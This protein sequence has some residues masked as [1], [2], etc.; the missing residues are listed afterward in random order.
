MLKL[1]S[2][3][4]SRYKS[5]IHPTSVFFFFSQPRNYV[6]VR[7]FSPV[8][9]LYE[10]E[11]QSSSSKDTATPWIRT[12]C[13]KPLLPQVNRWCWCAHYLIIDAE[14]EFLC[15]SKNLTDPFPRMSHSLIGSQI[16]RGG[17]GDTACGASSARNESH[18][19]SNQLET[20]AFIFFFFFF[21]I[22]TFETVL[23]EFCFPARVLERRERSLRRQQAAEHFFFSNFKALS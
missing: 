6:S 22:K 12:R 5:N 21:A 4:F 11:S 10:P 16:D 14:I 8:H 2:L 23:T 1:N 9:F 15:R 19:S 17:A 13:P 18:A 20:P 3:Y 7:V